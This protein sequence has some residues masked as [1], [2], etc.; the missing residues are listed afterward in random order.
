MNSQFLGS[1][2][3]KLEFLDHNSNNFEVLYSKTWG[4]KLKF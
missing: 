4:W 1:R 2:F 3:R